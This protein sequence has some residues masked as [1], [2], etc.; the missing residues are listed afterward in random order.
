MS[1]S[2][3][4]GGPVIPPDD[5]TG[6]NALIAHNSNNRTGF[7]GSI[8]GGYNYQSGNLLVGIE[9]DIGFM[10]TKRTQTHTFQ[11]GVL[12]E[13]PVTYTITNSVDTDWL[14]TIRPRLGYASGPW[15]V[16]ATAGLG[17]STIK[18]KATYAD[19]FSPP[20]NASISDSSTKVGFAGGVGVG[21]AFSHNWTMKGEWLYADIGSATA[22]A[23][24]SNGSAV[25]TA[26]GKAKANI[27]RLGVDYKF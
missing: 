11:S 3:V 16:Y 27:I 15:L 17:V 18:V 8:E 2:Q 12:I 20:G 23:T 22:N 14:W 9:S 10:D 4:P 21:Y 1:I 26:E 13:P 7:A 25:I 5:L 24:T 19:T 6:V